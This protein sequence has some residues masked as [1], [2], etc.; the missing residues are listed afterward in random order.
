MTAGSEEIVLYPGSATTVEFL[1]SDLVPGDIRKAVLTMKY[2][3]TDADSEAL[4]TKT[5]YL[6]AS[7]D[8]VISQDADCN[9]VSRP[10]MQFVLASEDTAPLA[11]GIKL[12]SALKLWPASGDD[13]YS[14]PKGRRG[15]RVEDPGVLTT[16]PT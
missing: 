3:L 16:A 5:I 1:L 15:V 6:A 11:I 13:P 12:F 7:S 2:R 9:D 14:P 8:G 4:L 10:L